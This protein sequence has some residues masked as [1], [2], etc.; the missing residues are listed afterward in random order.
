MS[1][2]TKAFLIQE[3]GRV[4]EARIRYVKAMDALAHAKGP[5]E[6]EQA[7]REWHTSY[8]EFSRIVRQHG[9]NMNIDHANNYPVYAWDASNVVLASKARILA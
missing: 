4:E 6:T 5:D 8:L 2:N 9:F 1:D 7:V 3:I